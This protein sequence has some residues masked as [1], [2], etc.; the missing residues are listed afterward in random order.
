MAQQLIAPPDI[1]PVT[2][3]EAK[4][5]ERID[6]E[7]V[8]DEESIETLLEAATRMAE[9]FTRRAFITQ[10]WIYQ[11]T[12]FGPIVE[13][14]R[15]RLQEV[16]EVTYTDWNN[17]TTI[18]DEDTYFTNSVYEPGRLIFKDGSFPF[19]WGLGWGYGAGGFLS[20]EYIAGYGDEEFDVPWQ[21]K[22][23]ILQIFGHLYENRESQVMPPG[24]KQILSPFK[25]EYL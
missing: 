25:V 9:E 1:L 8:G 3:S 13:L 23:G 18:I 15:P 21:I 17:N 11:T 5:H 10:G 4:I 7:D 2:V 12:C 14:P 19:G 16:A 24:A 22:E 6:T 20:V